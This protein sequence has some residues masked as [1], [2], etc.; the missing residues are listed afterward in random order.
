MFS[1]RSQQASS[2]KQRVLET[3]TLWALQ[4]SDASGDETDN[5][6]GWRKVLSKQTLI[7]IEVYAANELGKFFVTGPTDAATK[8]SHSTENYKEKNY[9]TLRH[10]LWARHFP[11]DQQMCFKTPNCHVLGFRGNVITEGEF[12]H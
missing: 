2:S 5:S 10:F 12:E 6:R 9:E 3:N 1:E 11:P 7:L 4:M 8:L